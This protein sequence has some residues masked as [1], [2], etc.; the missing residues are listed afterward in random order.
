V[1]RLAVLL[2]WG[3]LIG[4]LIGWPVSA[5]TIARDEPQFILGLSWLAIALTA[6]DFV[7]TSRVHRDQDGQDGQPKP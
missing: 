1:K 6:L 2:A 3:L 4:S 7:Q 5:M